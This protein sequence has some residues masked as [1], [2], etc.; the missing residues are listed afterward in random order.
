MTASRRDLR[1]NAWHS[2]TRSFDAARVADE[3][4]G[5]DATKVVRRSA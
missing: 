5:A 4:L 2:F 1:T 3:K